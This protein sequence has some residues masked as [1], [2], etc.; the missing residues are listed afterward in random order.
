MRYAVG[1]EYARELGCTFYRRLL[2][3]P[4]PLSADDALA[5]ARSDVLDDPEQ[6][7]YH[8][9]DHATPLMFGQT[10]RVLE[11]QHG[12]S[13]QM[14]RLR[15]H[16]QPLHTGGRTDL[17]PPAVF[18]GRGEL[19]SRLGREWLGEGGPAVALIQG[20]AGLGKTSLAA[21][22]IHLWHERFDYV[23]AFQARPTALQLDDMC[24]Q[25]DQRLMFESQRY[26]DKCAQ[27]PYSR[28]YL[29]PDAQM[30]PSPE[31]R[32]DRMRQNLIEAL[33]DEAILLVLDNFESNLERVETAEGSSVYACA[34]PNWDGLLLALARQLSSTPRSRLLVTTRHRPRALADAATT[35][36]IPLGP[37][38]MREAGLYLRTRPELRRLLFGNTSGKALVYRLLEIS[39]GHPLILDH[40]ARLARDP[41]VLSAALD[42]IQSEGWQGLPNLFGEGARDDAQRD[43]ERQYLEDVVMG[44]VDLLIGR[45]SP[46]AR[47]LLGVITL[48]NEPVREAFIAGVWQ[49]RSAEDEQLKRISQGIPCLYQLP[50]NDPR[51]QRLV[52][53]P[54]NDPRK[55]RLVARL[56][57]DTGQ[58]LLER[59]RNLALP[60]DA[61]PVGP[62]L[63]GL[64]GA[65]L[66]IQDVLAPSGVAGSATSAADGPGTGDSVTYSFHELVRERVAVWMAAHADQRASRPDDAIRVAYGERYAQLF[67]ILYHQNRDAANEAGRRALVYFVAA[68]AFDQLESFAS[69]LIT[70]V[71]DPALLR[72]MIAELG[73][74]NRSG[75]TGQDALV[76]AHLCG[77]CPSRGVLTGPGATAL[78]HGRRRSRSGV[79]LVRRGMDHRE[80][81]ACSLWCWRSRG[82]QTVAP[83]QCRCYT[84]SMRSGSP[85]D[86]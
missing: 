10:G 26:R 50:D 51:K 69:T 56:E 5:L 22:A 85:C 73:G 29:A 30:F 72:S 66:L 13:R 77:R 31:Q 83:S 57:T 33:R 37:L 4:G 1:D 25:L 54:D 48:A 2:A 17:D 49:G 70:G 67:N 45:L 86:Q 55:Q 8:V 65:G 28:I 42:R 74:H 61:P 58:Q 7:A 82:S 43:R 35:L 84:P 62:L 63:A 64:H 79:P 80:L 27:N 11:P 47:R 71:R 76:P 59:L 24:R 23:L 34:D 15:P 14:N 39:R 21:E 60:S 46:A 52:Q 53:L 19:L 12:R 16:P 9:V 6:T 3:D 68:R 32:Y 18:V 36:W 75:P 41:A 40:F 38:P 78:C 20:L 81:G 44:A